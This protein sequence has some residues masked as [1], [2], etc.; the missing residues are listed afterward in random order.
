VKKL[1]YFGDIIKLCCKTQLP[2]HEKLFQLGH[3]NTKIKVVS[4]QL[5]ARKLT[6]LAK[7]DEKSQFS[8]LSTHLIMFGL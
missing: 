8:A 2:Q 3:H 5:S 4:A 1:T 7:A 6:L